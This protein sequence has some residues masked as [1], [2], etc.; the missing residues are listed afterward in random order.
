[1]NEILK[2]E[3]IICISKKKVLSVLVISIAIL[4]EGTLNGRALPWYAV[5]IA[6]VN[7][8]IVQFKYEIPNDLAKAFTNIFCCLY[9]HI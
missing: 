9:V 3:K 7:V 5:R 8:I 1:M 2:S 4:L 6:L